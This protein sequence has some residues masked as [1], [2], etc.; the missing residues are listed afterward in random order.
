M[1][2]IYIYCIQYSHQQSVQGVVLAAT[3]QFMYKGGVLV[4][5]VQCTIHV[6]RCT[7]GDCTIHVQRCVLVVTV[8][9]MYK[10]VLVVT[11][12]FMYKGLY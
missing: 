6:Q 11:V 8:Q 7:S 2:R 10:G 5:T 3:V 4:V 12:Q 1:M 9:F